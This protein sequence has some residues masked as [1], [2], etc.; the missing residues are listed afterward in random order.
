VPARQ[1]R[2]PV[3]GRATSSVVMTATGYVDSGRGWAPLPLAV[4]GCDGLKR[5]ELRACSVRVSV[6]KVLLSMQFQ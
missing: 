3:R 4:L 5:L 6:A 1:G 2:A